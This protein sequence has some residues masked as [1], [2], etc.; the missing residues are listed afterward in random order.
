V[1]LSGRMSR[2]KSVQVKLMIWSAIG[3]LLTVA[4]LAGV[5]LFTT[6]GLVKSLTEMAQENTS[7]GLSRVIEV[8]ARQKWQQVD[9][10]SLAAEVQSMDWEQA[11]RLFREVVE[12]NDAIED[13]L[14]IN[15]GGNAMSLNGEAQVSQR[16][17]FTKSL[18]GQDALSEA[19]V[20]P[21]TDKRVIVFSSPIERDGA[22]VGVLALEILLTEF[23]DVVA[24]TEVAGGYAFVLDEDGTVIAHPDN[25]RI[26]KTNFATDS[27][28]SETLKKMSQDMIAGETGYATYEFQGEEKSAAYATV[29]NTGWSVST[30]IPVAVINAPLQK[31]FLYFGIAT[32]AA[33]FL[34][35]A[36][37]TAV[38]RQ[39]A[40]PIRLMAS[41]MEDISEGEGDLTQ[42]LDVISNDEVGVLARA[43][44]G[45]VLQIEHM[46]TQA[47]Y[48]SEDVAG[49]AEELSASTEE[50][51]ESFEQV[52]AAIEQVAAGATRQ[53]S[54]VQQMVG[55]MEEFSGSTEQIS[56]GAEEL[57]AS[58]ERITLNLGE[59]SQELEETSKRLENLRAKGK[60]SEEA[61][62]QGA[63]ATTRVI[64]AMDDIEAI[65]MQ[66][67]ERTSALARG[68]K[69]IGNVLETIEEIAEQTNLLALNAAIEAARA[70]EAGKGFAVVAD[71]VRKL[72]EQ[73]QREASEIGNLLE[74]I[75]T[76]IDQT[77]EGIERSGTQVKEGSKLADKAGTALNQI[78]SSSEETAD[79]IQNITGTVLKINDWSSDIHDNVSSFAAVIEENTASTE[80]MAAN[81]DEMVKGLEDVASISEETASGSQEVSA[82]TEE[83]TA[84]V[85][86]VAAT[87][88]S[89][90]KT[91]EK[92]AALVGRFKV[93][94]TQRRSEGEADDN[95]SRGSGEATLDAASGS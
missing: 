95:S 44:N 88:E 5:G 38:S 84:M 41:A 14:L 18:Q 77:I 78:V 82:S 67:T 63:D 32:A 89:L 21:R 57:S 43:F 86:E 87:A 73:S 62:S 17:Y 16:D 66:T 46:V 45:F 60:E 75:T 20:S 39:I 26:L 31:L 83:Q 7:S 58:V 90:A 65:V 24:K 48:L 30:T 56:A 8:W 22:I 55:T 76:N 61:A 27:D 29:S 13:I 10:L 68:S 47:N 4:L 25:E 49:S 81:S 19:Y 94:A 11:Q 34:G 9:E 59:M 79:L 28:I 71:E 2:M 37:M 23:S 3:I 69:Q 64:E 15:R 93:S 42:R 35:L 50:V 6:Q 12:T 74:E 36:I 51:G 52:S 1:G 91:A 72:A 33:L 92:M 80:E 53:S 70:G 54:R 40:A 85:E